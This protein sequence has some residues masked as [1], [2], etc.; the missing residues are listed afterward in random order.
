MN[1]AKNGESP[2]SI[3]LIRIATLDSN[4]IIIIILYHLNI[5][6]FLSRYLYSVYLECYLDA[7]ALYWLLESLKKSEQQQRW[8]ASKLS[9]IYTIKHGFSLGFT[10]SVAMKNEEF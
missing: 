5:F 2:L 4:S 10:V 6:S 7:L 1:F 9:N 3:A 8:P